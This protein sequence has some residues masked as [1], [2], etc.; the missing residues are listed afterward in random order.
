MKTIKLIFVVIFAMG[1]ISSCIERYYPETNA[2]FEAKL[3]I[4][5]NIVP[6][7]GEQEIVISYS[8]TS[9]KPDFLPVSGCLVRI[10]DDKGHH[11]PFQEFSAGHYRGT[12]TGQDVVIGNN[13]QLNVYT[14][15]GKEFISRPEE[16]LPCPA[17]D[18]VYYEY[19]QKPNANNDV[20]D[21]LQ[22]L[23]DVKADDSYGNFFRWELD[24]TYEYHSTVPLQQWLGEDGMHKLNPPDFSHYVC[25]KTERRPEILILSTEGFAQN[26]Y[27]KFKLHYVNDRTQRLR[28]GYS[29]LVKQYSISGKAYNY[30][31]NIKKNN[32]DAVDLFGRQPANVAG[33][34]YNLTDTTEHA[35]GYFMVSSVQTRRIMVK[36]VDGLPFKKLPRCLAQ[37]MDGPLPSDRPLYFAEWVTEQGE[38]TEGIIS[39]LCI[40]CELSGG[41][42]V[43]PSFWDRP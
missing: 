9:G 7:E 22:F 15:D 13:Y 35:L 43:K 20:E 23:I 29:L 26:S 3:V 42:T 19:Y 21:G 27:K 28:Y 18:Q 40:F 4:E 30:W 32:K 37:V 38:F 8:T 17:V 34:I 14:P 31:L 36:D 11:Y 25:Y 33:N 10:V 41:T 1:L 12:I 6:D 24:E 2:D 16:L 5:A 39:E